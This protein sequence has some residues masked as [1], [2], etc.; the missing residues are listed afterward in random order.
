MRLEICVSMVGIV[1]VASISGRMGT[2]PPPLIRSGEDTVIYAP[3]VSVCFVY[4][5]IGLR[6]CDVYYRLTTISS[7]SE[8][9]TLIIRQSQDVD[10]LRHWGSD[11]PQTL[12]RIDATGCY[13]VNTINAACIK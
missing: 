6:Y 2:G 13:A 4:S 1:P 8:A 11:S 5:C 7:K 10:S 3:T 9:Y 12:R